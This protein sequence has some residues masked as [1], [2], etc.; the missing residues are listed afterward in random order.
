MVR[1]SCGLYVFFNIFRLPSEDADR[2]LLIQCC[3]TSRNYHERIMKALLIHDMTLPVGQRLRFENVPVPTPKPG[4]LL[5]RIKAAAL[6]H[7]DEWI[8][9]GQ[10]AR[11]RPGVI[12]GSDGCGIVEKAASEHD[13]HWVGKEVIIN[14]SLNWGENTKAQDPQAY[15]ILGLPVHGTFAEY[16]AISTHQVAE[17]PAHLTAE[18]AAALPLAGLTAYRAVV[19]QS[20]LRAGQSVLI[21]GIGGGV[22]QCAAQFANALSVNVYATSSSQEKLR[23]AEQVLGI[24]GGALY[25]QAD[26]NKEL[27]SLVGELDAVIDG[28]GGANV[29]ALLMLLKYGGVYT[30]YGATNGR[31]AELNWQAVFWRQLRI[32]GTTMGSNAEFAAMVHLVSE[33]KIIPVIDSVRSFGDI[34]SAFDVMSSGEQFGKLV[35]TMK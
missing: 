28:A 3:K 15:S 29:N 21:T 32:Q 23:R 11:I 27:A 25:T 12:L 24:K 9:L 19:T 30:F 1:F 14:P 4:E 18:Q 6:N 7:R 22:A 34:L 8:R 33:K 16:I 35:V 20:L 13:D 2:F 5:V 31:P 10:Y 26:W 17:K